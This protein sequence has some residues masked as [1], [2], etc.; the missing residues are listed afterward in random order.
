M[1]KYLKKFHVIGDYGPQADNSIVRNY[2]A[3]SPENAKIMF[4]SRVQKEY[5]ESLWKKMGER[6]IS[7]FN[8]W[9]K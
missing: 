8:G 2:L 3:S 9:Y 6:N 7:V 5:P 1:K 4:I